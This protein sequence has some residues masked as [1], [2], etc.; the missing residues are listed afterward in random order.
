M[1][2]MSRTFLCAVGAVFLSVVW[3]DSVSAQSVGGGC[4][5]E[6]TLFSARQILRCGG[7]VTITAESGAQYTLL[8]RDGNGKIDAAN[9]RSKAL[10]LDAPKGSLGKSG[11]E[12]ITPQA[13]AA[14][15]GTRW[16]VDAEGAKTSVFVERG[17]VSVRRSAG[18]G[19]VTLGAGEGVDVEGTGPLIVK[20]W[21]AA[22]V[23][24]LM[25]RLSNNPR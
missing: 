20:R 12:V 22:R 21:P 19:S 15:R 4:A 18:R 23:D 16:A 9:L 5:L 3:V 7:G 1:V 2:S 24:A 13:I 25:A 6:Q 17:R 14:V 11:F 10:L 8:D